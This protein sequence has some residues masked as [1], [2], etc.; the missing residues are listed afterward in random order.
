VRLPVLEASGVDE[1]MR[2]IAGEHAPIHLLVV[3]VVTP[4]GGGRVLTEQLCGSHPGIK[5][6]FISGYADDAI[7]RHG[8]L[9]DQVN[10]LQKPLHHRRSR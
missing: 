9:R 10:F 7:V 5:V 6:L 2:L 3:D 1:T 8:I 4:G